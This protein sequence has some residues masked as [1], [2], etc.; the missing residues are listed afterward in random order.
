MNDGLTSLWYA[1]LGL[2]MAGNLT[3]YGIRK[4]FETTP[5]GTYSSSPGTI[6][7]ALKKLREKGLVA[8]TEMESEGSAAKKVFCITGKGEKTLKRWLLKPVTRDQVRLHP[9]ILMLRFAF[10]DYLNDPQAKI[11]FLEAF[12]DESARLVK[13]ITAFREAEKEVMP[14]NGLLALDSGILGTKAKVKWASYALKVLRKF[15]SSAKP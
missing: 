1:I 6:Y 7:P 4:I 12:R 13:E 11:R 10:M 15:H 2:L 14:I 3:G 8:R 9:E 5:L